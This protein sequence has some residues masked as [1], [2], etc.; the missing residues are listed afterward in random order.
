[1]QHQD[2][3]YPSKHGVKRIRRIRLYPKLDA[4]E[5]LM[6]YMGAYELDNRQSVGHDL[7]TRSIQDLEEELASIQR[8]R[9]SFE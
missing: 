4:I 8:R 7:S 6:R 9:A 1:M 2:D 5:K 3:E